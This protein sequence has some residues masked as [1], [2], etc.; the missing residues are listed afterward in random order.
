MIP[1]WYFE[2]KSDLK[3]NNEKLYDM[4]VFSI[5]LIII[6]SVWAL[7]YGNICQGLS[8]LAIDALIHWVF[9]DGFINLIRSRNFYAHFTV[10][11]SDDFGDKWHKWFY[12]RKLNLAII[13]TVLLAISIALYIIIY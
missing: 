3:G 7:Y 6:N 9:H 12:D 4:I 11:N 10:D 8:L 5:L 1:T 13:V 2:A